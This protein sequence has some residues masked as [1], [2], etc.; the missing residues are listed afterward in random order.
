LNYCPKCGMRLAT[1]LEGGR[2]RLACPECTYVFFGEFSIGVGGVVIRDGKALLIRRGQ[3]PRRGWWQIPGGYAE[4]DEEIDQA[5]AREVF[6]ESGVSARPLGV[7]GL[8]NMLGDPSTN[9]YV[10]FAME[11]TGGEPRADG[12]EITGVGFFS[13]EELDA[14]D[15]VQSLS[16]WAIRTALANGNPYRAIEE[17]DLRRPGYLLFG[18]H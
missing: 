12:E 15:K 5:V 17:G 18:P 14:M 4:H 10:I 2:E 7:L 6:E 11:S 9:I 16:K 3:E 8:R 1:R 13:P